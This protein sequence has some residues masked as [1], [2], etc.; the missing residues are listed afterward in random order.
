MKKSLW[1]AGSLL[2]GL[3]GVPG[4]YASPAPSASGLNTLYGQQ[5]ESCLSDQSMLKSFNQPQYNQQSAALNDQ[6]ARATHYLMLRDQLSGDMQPVMDKIYQA[7]LTAQCQSVHNALFNILL[8][9]A[10]GVSVLSPRSSR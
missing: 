2:S 9:Q 3:L 1:I 4:A 7:R 10:D 8:T 5:L 6:I